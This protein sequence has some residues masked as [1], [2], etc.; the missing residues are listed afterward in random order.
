MGCLCCWAP[1]CPRRA[2]SWISLPKY[3]VSCALYLTSCIFYILCLSF[4]LQTGGG[5]FVLLGT[6]TSKAGIV[7]MDVVREKVED[8]AKDIVLKAALNKKTATADPKE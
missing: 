8:M 4:C 6:H 2:F 7:P 1:T 5:V 3:S